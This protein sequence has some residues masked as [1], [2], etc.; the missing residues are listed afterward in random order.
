MTLSANRKILI[1]VSHLRKSMSKHELTIKLN[2][3][4]SVAIPDKN[5]R[6]YII[7]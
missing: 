2:E 3:Y 1:G 5:Y 6:I 7:I 4:I